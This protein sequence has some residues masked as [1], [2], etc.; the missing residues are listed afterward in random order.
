MWLLNTDIV[1]GNAARQWPLIAVSHVRF[2]L[3]EKKYEWKRRITANEAHFRDCCRNTGHFL[4]VVERVK[5][6]VNVDLHFIISNLKRISKMSTLPPWKNYCGRPSMSIGST[7]RC[8]RTKPVQQS[9][10]LIVEWPLSFPA[11]FPA[12]CGLPAF[13]GG[14]WALIKISLLCFLYLCKW[15]DVNW[16][17]SFTTTFVIW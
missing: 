3:R 10:H 1:S 8:D 7:A 6:F 5:R 16:F 15:R 2:I 4:C 11:A 17:T 12:E 9:R 14:W 13:S